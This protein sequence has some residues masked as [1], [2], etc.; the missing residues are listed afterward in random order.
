MLIQLL[1]LILDAVFSFMSGVLLAR[2]LMQWLRL[3]FRNPVGNF[4]V[5]ASDWMV[6]P[7][8]RI[9]PGLFGLD[10]SS[11]VLAWLLQTVL[12]VLTVLLHGAGFGDGALLAVLALVGVLDTLRSAVYLVI[13]AVIVSAVLSWVNPYSP[14]GPLVNGLAR[15]FL[16][17]FQRI[18]PPVGNVDLSPLALLLVLQVALFLLNSLKASLLGF[19]FA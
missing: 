2:F 11:L 10:L 6:R 13:G 19:G 14:I 4:V 15:P 1:L 8:R 3:P 18:I 16:R 17:P 9:I 7:A 5:A 12:L